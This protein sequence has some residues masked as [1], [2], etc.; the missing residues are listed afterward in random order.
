[1]VIGAA[2]EYYRLLLRAR[3]EYEKAQEVVEDIV[4]SFDRQ[5]KKEAEKIESVTYK[6]EMLTA[7]SDDAVKKTKVSERA[8]QLLEGKL[9][10]ILEE[11][12]NTPAKIVELDKKICDLT[13]SQGSL[14]TK[15]TAIEEG[16]KQ[17]AVSPE[18]N[19]EA[20]IPIKRDKALA[21][22]TGTELTALEMLAAEGPKT[23]PE[24]KEKL[25]LSREHTARLMKKLYDSGYLERDTGK[26]P[27]KYSVKK[28]M[29]NLLKK[30]EN[31]AT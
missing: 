9:T 7:K 22:L 27:F 6:V 2:I 24:I 29:E 17:Y 12:R 31:K 23:A 21:P 20:V 19:V 13:E 18:A 4:L 1:M 11:N 5:L 16:A 10:A 14:A 3:N 25:K 26:I 30:S 28:E 8:L 15:I